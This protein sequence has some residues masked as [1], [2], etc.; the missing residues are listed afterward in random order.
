M[1]KADVIDHV[2]KSTTL[3]RS[4]ATAAVDSVFDALRS[5]LCAGEN[6]YI[7]G[8][9][10]FAICERRAK[11]A[12]DFLNCRTVDIPAGLTVKLKINRE[13]KEQMQKLIKINRDVRKS[14]KVVF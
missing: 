1:K 7:R 3:S 14:Y 10:T 6:V 11:K 9:A 4:Q 2:V 12:R 13:I 5:S 8:F